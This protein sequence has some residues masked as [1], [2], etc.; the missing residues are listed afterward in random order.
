MINIKVLS[1]H[2]VVEVLAEL[3]PAFQRASGHA[4]SFSYNPTAAI[5]REIDVGAAFDVAIIT[6]PAVD[7]LAAQG[8][9]LREGSADLARCGLG[10][11]VR[12]GAA[13]PDIGTV[14][15]FKHALLNAKSVVRSKDG[16]SG[17][18]FEALLERLGITGA[19]RGKIIV[20]PAGRI[21]ELVARGEGELAIQQVPE[22]VPVKGADFVGPFPAEL[23]V[24]TVFAAGVATA[25]KHR[26]A[27][28]AFIEALAAPSAA[29]LYKAKGLEPIVRAM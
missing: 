15:A 4:L 12:Q 14:E 3:A 16:A 23:Q 26:D 29:A 24:Y 22:L 9:I 17:K 25:S 10:V 19:M 21:A 7:E 27:A 2:A 5:R 6:R 13:K 1:T 28:K 11:S 20:G 18:S 8:V